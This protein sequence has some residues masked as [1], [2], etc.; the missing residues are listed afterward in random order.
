MKKFIHLLALSFCLFA[1][2]SFMPEPR[3]VAGTYTVGVMN[4]NKVELKLNNDHTFSYQD[5][6][7]AEKPVT[8]TGRWVEQGEY[9]L[10]KDYVSTISFHDKWMITADGQFAKAKAGLTFYTLQKQAGC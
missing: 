9:V 6:S 8:V 2:M 5:L 10:L 1:V 4:P 3:N 7:N